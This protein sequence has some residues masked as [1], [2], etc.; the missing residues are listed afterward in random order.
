MG[1][2]WQEVEHE[3]QCALAAKRVNCVLERTRPSIATG[4]RF[5]APQYEKD[6]LT[7][8]GLRR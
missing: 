2:G 7:K 6:I 5:G 8:R 4:C 3:P 1:S